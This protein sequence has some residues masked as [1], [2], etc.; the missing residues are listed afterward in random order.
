MIENK[1]PAS[2][3]SLLSVWTSSSISPQPPRCLDLSGFLVVW[4]PHHSDALLCWTTLHSGYLSPPP[5]CYL[6]VRVA[7][8]KHCAFTV[9]SCVAQQGISHAAWPVWCTALLHKHEGLKTRV[10]RFTSHLLNHMHGIKHMTASGSPPVSAAVGVCACE[11][12]LKGILL[13]PWCHYKYESLLPRKP[14]WH[15]PSGAYLYTQLWKIGG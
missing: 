7:I 15:A 9:H 4:L 6:R 12:N 3:H 10:L 13:N 1:C 8:N 14:P 5:V 2:C 11:D